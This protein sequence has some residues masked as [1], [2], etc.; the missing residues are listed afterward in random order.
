MLKLYK[1]PK[2]FVL[3]HIF[4]LTSLFFFANHIMV[5]SQFVPPPANQEYNPTTYFGNPPRGCD[6]R[7]CTCPPCLKLFD[8]DVID[9]ITG[10][11][12]G[13]YAVDCTSWLCPTPGTGNCGTGGGSGDP[14]PTWAVPFP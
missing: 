9:H 1:F 2:F 8:P 13:R 10:L 4:V 11:S 3:I 12:F 5:Q 14:E 6:G 7:P